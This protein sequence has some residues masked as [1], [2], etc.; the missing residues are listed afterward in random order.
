MSQIMK[1]RSLQAFLQLFKI[2][3]SH[4]ICKASYFELMVGS[5]RVSNYEATIIASFSTVIRTLIILQFMSIDITIFS[6][7]DIRK[8][9][10]PDS[11][12]KIVKV[13]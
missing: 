6:H 9:P 1:Q 3:S 12:A 11:P 7:D 8:W 13:R 5:C 10:F 2:G 4:R